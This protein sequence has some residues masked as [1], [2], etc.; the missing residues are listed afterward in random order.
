MDYDVPFN[1]AP[2][3]VNTGDYASAQQDRI[4]ATGG[5]G[6]APDA[7]DNTITAQ[8]P[9]A[10]AGVGGSQPSGG[11]YFGNQGEQP[12][13]SVSAQQGYYGGQ[14]EGAYSGQSYQG[15]GGGY[16]TGEQ[17]AP[18]APPTAYVG[19]GQG[20]YESPTTGQG[21]GGEGTYQLG[22][23]TYGYVAPPPSQ[24]YG[25]GGYY[26]GEQGAVPSQPDAGQPQ[27]AYAPPQG[28]TGGG[29]Y[30]GQQGAQTYP[31]QA[32]NAPSEAT[33][34]AGQQLVVLPATDL[35]SRTYVRK[36]TIGN[37]YEIRAARI[38]LRRSQ[39]PQV[40]DY[41]RQMLD[42]HRQALATITQ[43]SIQ[44]GVPMAGPPLDPS[45]RM[46]LAKLRRVPARNFDAVY[47]NQ[48]V[49][50]H[51]N[52]AA[53]Q[54][55]YA[56]S[57]DNAV[58]QQ[59]AA[60]L[61][62]NVQQ[63]LTF[64]WSLSG[65]PARLASQRSTELAL[66][67]QNA[68]R[69]QTYRGYTVIGPTSESEL[70]GRGYPTYRGYTHRGSHYRGY[71][72]YGG[73]GYAG[74]QRRLGGYYDQYNYYSL[75]GAAP[76]GV[77]YQQGATGG[78]YQGYTSGAGAQP[79]TAGTTTPGYQGYTTPSTPGYQGYT[80]PSTPS[81]PASPGYTGPGSGVIPGTPGYTGPGSP[82][83]TGPGSGYTGPGSGLIKPNPNSPNPNG[84]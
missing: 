45:H 50:A 75:K 12:L 71:S 55:G 37:M 22:Q 76:A 19:Q 7:S 66:L 48:Q 43:A 58:L 47:M 1:Q 11:Y 3:G 74:R 84:S 27:G 67:D 72:R 73:A 82:G 35:T 33:A 8:S 65:Q 51:M 21:L 39:S 56:R 40:R 15:Y 49:V 44:A 57:G 41:A 20:S 18:S 61:D 10:G 63:N 29:Y 13:Q 54:R 77:A 78:A 80:S 60:Q 23:P 25:G 4:S 32:Y 14:P 42:Q 34:N 6:Y 5:E 46:M 59:T 52:Q 62:P 28:Y 24:G 79:G 69:G 36:T 81:T 38:A 68:G 30:T 64:A 9:Q 16:Y 26:T 31:S 70:A 2:T 53:V 83:Y 17:G